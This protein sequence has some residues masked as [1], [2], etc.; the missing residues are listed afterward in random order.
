TLEMKRESSTKWIVTNATGGA[1]ALKEP[2]A[3]YSAKVEELLNLV[4]RQKV[5]KFLDPKKPEPSTT[6]KLDLKDDALWI[7]IGVAGEKANETVPYTLKVG[8]SSSTPPG[9]YA[10][11]SVLPGDQVFI[12]GS[13]DN[14]PGDQS[15]S[16]FTQIRKGAPPKYFGK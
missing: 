12:L 4:M 5:A 16:P 9:W 8:G 2:D 1:D 10:Q 3:L 6:T 14:L 13:Q 11:S 7:E 15:N